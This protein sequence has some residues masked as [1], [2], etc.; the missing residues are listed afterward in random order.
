MLRAA[1]RYSRKRV[2]VCATSVLVLGAPALLAPPG[3]LLLAASALAA[4]LATQVTAPLGRFTPAMAA[5]AA[6]AVSVLTDFLYRG[7]Q[8][9]TLL[10]MPFEYAGLLVLLGRLI[11]RRGD[12]VLAWGFAAG[13]VTT[14]LPLRFTLRNPPSD[15][16][17][18]LTALVLSLLP[19]L[20]AIATGRYLRAS[21]ARRSRAVRRAREEQ[22]DFLA[23]MLHDH[24]AHELTGMVVEVQAARAAPYGAE[25]YDAFLA[26][27]EDSGL[28][29]LDHMDRALHT[30]RAD[31]E[32]TTD[33]GGEPATRSRGL[34]SLPELVER[35]AHSTGRPATLDLPP[36]LEGALSPAGEQAAHDLVLEALTNIRRHTP[37]A[38]HVAVT[39]ARAGDR[40]EVSVSNTSD[41]GRAS[42]SRGRGSGG[43][44]LIGLGERFALLDGELTSGPSAEGWRVTGWLPAEGAPRAR[45]SSGHH[46]AGF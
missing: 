28:R 10:W 9:L 36:G 45:T 38:P 25:E 26:R 6:M 33:G 19:V 46:P 43:T 16:R 35:F 17:D 13:L 3:A 27:L 8:G 29:A 12:D 44:G 24:V 14:A 11:R 42:L 4:V 37:R 34:T 5:G 32:R 31:D 41:G 22:R 15:G 7:G 39:L 21:D 18:A 1:C 23:R 40:V 2:L 30:L 20:C